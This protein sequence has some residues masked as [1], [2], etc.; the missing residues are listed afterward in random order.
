[1]AVIQLTHHMQVTVAMVALAVAAVAGIAIQQH[2]PKAAT[3]A[4]G[5]M[6]A[7]AAAA[8][9]EIY[10]QPHLKAATAALAEHTAAVAA[11]LL[12][13]TGQELVELAEHTAA[14]AQTV[15]R[16]RAGAM[17]QYFQ[18]LIWKCCLTMQH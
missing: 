14:K 10:P 8:V 6:V 15:E 13:I 9:L 7:E 3:A 5:R 11:A 17:V 12:A 18:M 16:H 1:M 2:T 4:T